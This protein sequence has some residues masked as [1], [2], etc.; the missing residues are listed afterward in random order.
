MRANPEPRENVPVA[1]GQGAST[2]GPGHRPACSNPK[3]R[4]MPCAG[5]SLPGLFPFGSGSGEALPER[6]GLAFR[7]LAFNPFDQTHPPATRRKVFDHLFV[8]SIVIEH[9]FDAHILTIA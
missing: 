4:P 5:R 3:T 2:S 1:Y 8:P 7:N 9:G 6:D